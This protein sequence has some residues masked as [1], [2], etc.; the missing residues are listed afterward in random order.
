MRK[1]A[2]KAP[3]ARNR[4]LDGATL[5]L[6]PCQRPVLAIQSTKG[7][8]GSSPGLAL[9]GATLLAGGVAWRKHRRV[10]VGVARGFAHAAV[11]R[12]ARPPARPRPP[13]E[14][15]WTAADD[16]IDTTLA[17]QRASMLRK[18]R[19]RLGLSEETVAKLKAIIDSSQ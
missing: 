18:M 9:I 15:P 6:A 1:A 14:P 3:S 11:A 7:H 2:W 16:A 19:E 8:S 17:N 5:V 12:L 10:P 4:L 13:T